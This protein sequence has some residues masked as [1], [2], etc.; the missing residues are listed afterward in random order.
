M[1]VKS[2]CAGPTG[3]SQVK[4]QAVVGRVGESVILGCD[5]LNAEEAR[6]HLYVIEWVR[7]GFLLPI[8]IKFGL[9]SPRIDP[10]YV[11]E[12]MLGQQ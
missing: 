9:Y 3:N 1:S 2:P 7:F 11:G 4:S 5:L 6:P 8:F 12:C 10:E